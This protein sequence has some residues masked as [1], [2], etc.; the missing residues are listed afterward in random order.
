M[1]SILE[2]FH[3]ILR[4]LRSTRGFV[5]RRWA[6]FLAFL[7]RR[8]YVWRLWDD[9]KR[10]T[11][12]R[13][14]S[15]QARRSSPCTR[16][17]LDLR[18]YVIAASYI[19]ASATRSAGHL[20]S[21]HYMSSATQQP[22]PATASGVPL[23]PASL[24]VESPSHRD[25]VD[26]SPVTDARIDHNRRSS[27][28]SV[29]SRS[30]DR[31]SIIRTYSR[32]SLY[33]PV[34]QPT[35][36]PR[37]PHRQFGRGHSLSPSR[38]SSLSPSP[39]PQ[40]HRDHA[41][42]SSVSDARIDPNRG[43]SDSSAQRRSGD[44][45]SII[46]TH[47]R[48]SFTM[49]VGQPTRFPR[50]PHRQFGRGP[51]VPLSRESSRSPSPSPQLPPDID[52]ITPHP[53]SQLDSGN[54]P[55]SPLSVTSHGHAPLSSPSIHSLRG[56]ESSTSVV[57][58]V[59]NPSTD[60]LPPRFFTD[61]QPLREEPYTIDSPTGHLS[62]PDFDAHERFEGLPQHNFTSSSSSAT[63]NFDPP[64]GRSLRLITS[65]QVPR[66]T[67]DVTVQVDNTITTIKRLRLLADPAKAHTTKYRL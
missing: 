53:Q 43:S 35:R 16:T 36:S 42:P 8:L 33:M 41:S 24:S 45:P 26:F 50:A 59:V 49:P 15:E 23:T 65:E 37:A 1:A 30:S 31:L 6:L 56:R 55:I 19:P 4:K 60:S 11:F 52:V 34:S 47:S 5:F 64:F 67:K 28:S 14:D 20:A 46:Q 38:E 12:P 22:Q 27:D 32:E 9:R 39:T 48:E 54:S 25:H 13:V 2:L 7:G 10:G 44:R 63:S 62:V 58:G 29:R 21:F 61:G 57:V 3:D 51:S 17:D 40:S 18:K 66:Y